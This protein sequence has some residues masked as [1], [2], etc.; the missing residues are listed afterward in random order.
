MTSANLT[1]IFRSD[2]EEPRIKK[3]ICRYCSGLLH[4][5]YF[6]FILSSVK[7]EMF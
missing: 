5:T 4:I 3:D 2:E 6:N 7:V 1:K